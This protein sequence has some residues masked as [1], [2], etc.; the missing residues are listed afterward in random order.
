MEDIEIKIDP[1]IKKGELYAFYK[2]N[3]ICESG[4]GPKRSELVLRYPCVT[5]VAFKGG[6]LIGFARA[7]FDGLHA[8]IQEFSLDLR[9]QDTNEL[10]NGCFVDSDPQGIAKR[11]GE[12][13]LSDIRRRGGCFF[14]IS[15][16]RTGQQAFYA[17][18][19]FHENKGAKEFIIDERPYVKKKG[20]TKESRQRGN[21]RA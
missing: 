5:V 11:M 4:Y 9:F 10:R 2:R 7:L 15:A 16:W 8:A 17:A 3:G 13:L 21:P 18:L 12:K 6:D 19:G 20:P 1:P 14:S